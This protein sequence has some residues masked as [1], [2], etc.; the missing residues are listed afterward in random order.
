[1]S[2]AFEQKYMEKL[3]NTKVI[4]GV[5]KFSFDIF[6]RR[7]SSHIIFFTKV[8]HTYCLHSSKCVKIMYNAIRRWK[9]GRSYRWRNVYGF[10]QNAYLHENGIKNFASEFF[11]ENILQI[12]MND[13]T[14]FPLSYWIEPFS[15]LFSPLLSLDVQ[16]VTIQT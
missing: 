2:S 16:W 3:E 12:S 8:N 7:N 14:S 9:R 5:E 4:T 10:V 6:I 15:C 11:Y 1:M 13:I